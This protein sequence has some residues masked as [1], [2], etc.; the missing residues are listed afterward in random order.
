MNNKVSILKMIED[1]NLECINCAPQDS[2]VES[3]DVNR[4]GMQLIGYFEHFPFERIQVIGNAEY[5]YLDGLRAEDRQHVLEKFLS[6]D[7]P[8]ICV[9]RGQIVPEEL[10]QLAIKHNKFVIRTDLPT[11]RFM[12]RISDYI[13]DRIAPIEVVHGVLVDVDGLGILIKGESGIGKSEA[14]LE[15]IQRGHRF[16]SDDAVEI[17]RLEDDVLVGQSPELTRH[18]MEIRGIGILDIKSLYGVG[19]VKPSKTIDLIATLE[20]WDDSRQYDRLGMDEEYVEVLGVKIAH[21]VIPIRP[22]RNISVILEIA[23][24]NQR[25]KY[26]GYNA[27]LALNERLLS[28]LQE[29]S[30][31]SESI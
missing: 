1:L 21:M 7:I 4:P 9:T 20:K 2:Y 8:L 11:T 23:A 22:G 16:V 15:L 30:K 10:V 26:M 3:S 31:S 12:S 25:Q 13:N 5:S 14:A 18:I 6:Y 28:K 17:K 29:S 19:A 27:A 24:R